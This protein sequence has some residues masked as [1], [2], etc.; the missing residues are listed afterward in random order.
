MLLNNI[1]KKLAKNSNLRLLSSKAGLPEITLGGDK[2]GYAHYTITERVPKTIRQVID[3]VDKTL[4]LHTSDKTFTKQ[5]EL[6]KE[7]LNGL[8][9]D[10]SQNRRIP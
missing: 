10:V 3:D 4:E 9:D 5:G 7:E 2:S 1:T 6:I 8:I